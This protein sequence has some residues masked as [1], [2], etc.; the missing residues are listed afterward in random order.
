MLLAAIAPERSS[1]HVEEAQIMLERLVIAPVELIMLDAE[2]LAGSSAE[3]VLGRIKAA[4]PATRCL[5]LAK[6]VGQQEELKRLDGEEVLLQGTPA[7]EIATAIER[8]LNA[9]ATST[10]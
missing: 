9:S 5:I 4:S 3:K 1:E 2:L 8:L 7:A 6:T 10:N